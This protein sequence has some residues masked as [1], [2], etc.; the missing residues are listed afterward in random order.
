MCKV[1]DKVAFL[2]ETIDALT[3][4]E[5]LCEIFTVKFGEGHDDFEQ[6]Y[7]DKFKAYLKDASPELIRQS[8][9]GN[10]IAEIA[11]KYAISKKINPVGFNQLFHQIFT[12]HYGKETAR[13]LFK[14]ITGEEFQEKKKGD[15][16]EGYES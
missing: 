10:L 14:I 5:E 4:Y 11:V 3:P 8:L 12:H 15:S 1:C 7:L 13:Q 6:E 9:Y 2:I 16:L